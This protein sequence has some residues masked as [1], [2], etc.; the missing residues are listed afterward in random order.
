[1]NYWLGDKTNNGRSGERYAMDSLNSTWRPRLCWWLP[2]CPGEDISPDHRR[3][4]DRPEDQP[5]EQEDRVNDI[6]HSK[7]PTPTP[8]VQMNREDLP[9]TEES[10]HLGSTGN[11]VFCYDY[12]LMGK[13]WNNDNAWTNEI[14]VGTKNK[15]LHV[16]GGKNKSHPQDMRKWL[17]TQNAM[18][19]QTK[20]RSEQG[21]A[22]LPRWSQWG[23]KVSVLLLINC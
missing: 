19:Q 4:E 2:T 17:E 5:A 21:A 8:P 6:E 1:M 15:E 11:L 10:T 14:K 7:H 12:P 13:Q 3:L 9:T 16:I 23:K 20:T 18:R 22:R